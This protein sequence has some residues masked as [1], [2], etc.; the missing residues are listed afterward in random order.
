MK[1]V[2]TKQKC[3]EGVITCALRSDWSPEV[4]VAMKVLRG[5]LQH[6]MPHVVVTDTVNGEALESSPTL[7]KKLYATKY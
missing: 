5:V 2:H 7:Y 4:C 3:D 6:P 1:L